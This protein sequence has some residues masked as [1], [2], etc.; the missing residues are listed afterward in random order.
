[1]IAGE[2]GN[3]RAGTEALFQ[4]YG[5]SQQ[6]AFAVS[7]PTNFDSL[8]PANSWVI[9][10]ADDFVNHPILNG[11]TGLEFLAS[12]SLSPNTDAIVTTDADANPVTVPVMAAF[13][14]GAGC[15]SLST[16]TN[17]ISVIGA[18]DGYFKQN[19]ARVA[20][21]T[22]T[23]L[24]GCTSLKL[25]KLAAPSPVQAG[26]LLT[27]TLTASNDSATPVT[28]VII[29]DTIPLSS[30]FAGASSPFSGP[31]ANGVVTWSLATLNP[32]TSATRTLVVQVDGAVPLGTVITNTAWISSSQGLTDTATT[33]TPVNL[34]MVN[35][36][37]T[38][39][40]N[41]NQAV[42]GQVVTFTLTVQQAAQ[43][44]SNATNIRVVDPLPAELDILN[45]EATAGFTTVVGQVVTW[46]IP[47]LS[48]A[49]VRLMTIR[50]RVN[51]AGAPPLTIQNQA[52]LRFDQGVDRLSNLVEILIPGQAPTATPIPTPTSPPPTRASDDDDDD[53]DD[54]PDPAP[55][56]ATPVPATAVSQTA[57]VAPAALPVAFLPETGNRAASWPRLDWIM[58]GVVLVLAV[59]VLREIFAGK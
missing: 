1:M 36:L 53:D 32:N 7:D 14:D 58:P 49:D 2:F 15:V 11:V 57:P 9:Y 59:M 44:N 18:I 51:S 35:P 48:P 28:N 26:G 13:T 12:S 16:D 10:Q 24:N 22:V 33:F 3:F 37:I 40:V 6:G 5:Y 20:R 25:S 8:G 17:W 30:T 29:T 46:T 39:A 23:W 42:V 21:Q 41:V 50:A 43:S 55:P 56:P 52:S 4:A 54:D 31:D 19:N 47:V 34:P 27:Y 45:A 38:K